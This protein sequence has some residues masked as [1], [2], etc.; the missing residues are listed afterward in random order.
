MSEN[1][2]NCCVFNQHF[3]YKHYTLYD[4]SDVKKFITSHETWL[5]KSYNVQKEN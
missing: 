3:V 4:F 2:V 5:D 1:H